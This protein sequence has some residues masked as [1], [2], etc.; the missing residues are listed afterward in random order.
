MLIPNKKFDE[1][2]A[3]INNPKIQ[4]NQ[5]SVNFEHWFFLEFEPLIS[6]NIIL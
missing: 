4:K 5:K 1:E 6:K 2:I 3:V